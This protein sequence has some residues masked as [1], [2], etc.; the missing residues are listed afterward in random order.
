M[1]QLSQSVFGR[2]TAVVTACALTFFTLTVSTKAEP[3][4]SE[5]FGVIT[6]FVIG[7]AAGIVSDPIVHEIVKEPDPSPAAPKVKAWGKTTVHLSNG[8]FIE[9]DGYVEVYSRS[10]G[11]Y[12]L[13]ASMPGIDTMPS[14]VIQETG[15]VEGTVDNQLLLSFN[16]INEQA[17]VVDPGLVSLGADYV[18][19][20]VIRNGTATWTRPGGAVGDGLMTI[21]ISIDD[22]VLTTTSITNTTGTAAY[23]LEISS[24]E[25]GLIFYAQGFVRQD[26]TLYT[27]GDI[28]AG[29]YVTVTGSGHATLDHTT[30]VTAPVPASLSSTT[31]DV[32]LRTV[33]GGLLVGPGTGPIPTLPEW[34]LIILAISAFVGVVWTVTRR[35]KGWQPV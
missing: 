21:D 17:N 2:I 27:R 34:G 31:L 16:N 30:Q 23:E 32:K 12:T 11:Q 14:F 13:P 26:G 25:L 35:R 5:D 15:T 29:S 18:S 8:T 1:N 4:E 28:S 3:N 24:P 9:S 20:E 6:A 33:G 19:Y 7:V 10:V 22:L